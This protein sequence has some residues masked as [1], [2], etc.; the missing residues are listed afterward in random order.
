MLSI[1]YAIYFVLYTDIC[2]D[3]YSNG[4]EGSDNGVV[5]GSPGGGGVHKGKGVSESTRSFD[6]L[7]RR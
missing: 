6:G 1:L 2:Y 5:G 4:G 3:I 7:T